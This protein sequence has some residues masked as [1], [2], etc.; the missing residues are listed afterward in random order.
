MHQDDASDSAGQSAGNA[1]DM[2][3]PA[4]FVAALANCRASSGG[5]QLVI[6]VIRLDRFASACE[7]VGP[8]GAAR[9]RQL[10]QARL[11]RWLLPEAR[12]YWLGPADLAVVTPLSAA[13]QDP[14]R[15]G[16]RMADEL[17]RPFSLDGFELFLS[18]S[19]GV[20][21]D[22]PDI[23]A[24]RILQQA[25]DAMLRICRQGGHGLGSAMRAGTPAAD[26]MV[27]ALPHALE[28][29]E[30]SL[31]LQPMAHFEGA[32]IS[33]Y[34]VRL[35]WRHPALGRVAPQDFLPA[36]ENLGL[37]G[38]VGN[39][40]LGS[41]APLARAAA[42]IGPLQFTLQASSAQLHQLDMIDALART[43]DAGAIAPQRLCVE[44]PCTNLPDDAE[45]LARFEALRR[46]GLQLSLSDFDSRPECLETFDWL[47]PD[48]VTLDVRSLGHAHQPA[49]AA[50][51][52][53]A[54]C[55]VARKAGAVVCARGVETRKQLEQVHGWGCHSIQG[56]LL[57]QPFPAAWLAQ[58]HWAIQQR[59]RELLGPA[60]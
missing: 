51:G 25:F 1:Y 60:T 50:A 38:P 58:T 3:Q 59:A 8:K 4:A 15:L 32:R 56:Y 55:A 53:Q 18:C 45:L 37:M 30:L 19:I 7:S 57:A 35:R 41:L 48:R 20:A 16:Q 2:V 17:A 33:G 28:R 11:A 5:T 40:L 21:L 23:A 27:A 54:A 22:H 26:Q 6:L 42:D 14:A 13:T 47:R 29:G 52:L 12:M 39:W 44:V 43:L 31:H 46:R 49:N 34:S 10:V 24:E 9:L 36:L